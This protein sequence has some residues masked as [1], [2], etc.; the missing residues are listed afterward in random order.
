MTVN[1]LWGVLN[2]HA[3]LRPFSAG[4]RLFP[5][6]WP[7]L[8]FISSLLLGRHSDLLGDSRVSLLGLSSCFRRRSLS[9]FLL[10]V[11]LLSKWPGSPQVQHVD[12]L[13][14]LRRVGENQLP[15][16]RSGT[17]FVWPSG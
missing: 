13:A 2:V 10:Y 15:P 16:G 8:L 4:P 5:N 9:A 7:P 17:R 3:G 6:G 14:T 12:F 11:Q 1:A